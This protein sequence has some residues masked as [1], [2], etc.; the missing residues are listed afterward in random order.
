MKS[1]KLFYPLCILLLCG[2]FVNRSCTSQKSEKES[3]AIPAAPD[4]D[5]GAFPATVIAN[6]HVRM[7]VYLPDAEKGL[8]RGTRFDWSGVIGSVR[9]KDHE[10]FGYWKETHDPLFHED[11]TGP[12]EGFIEPG[13]G[14]AE[15]RP[16]EGFIRIGVGI[17]EKADEPAFN[18]RKTYKILDHGRWKT[19]NGT[20]WISFTHQ[21]NNNS[22]YAYTY[23]KTIKLKDDGFTIE[24]NLLNTGALAIETD[25]FNHNFFMIDGEPSGTSFQLSFPFAI[26]TEDDLK[27]YLEIDE[28]QLSFIGDLEKD[29]SVFL[30]LEGYSH[31]PQDH[32]V[33]VLNRKTGAGVTFTVDQPIYR[34]AFWA[35]RT[36]LSPE[37]SVWISVAPGREH[38]WISD[39]T[40]FIKAI[41]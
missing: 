36:T 3:V 9:F 5:F 1:L 16:G 6:D 15:A 22:G 24:H 41:P 37:N 40:L 7:K 35:C 8:Y 39:Y 2:V 12:V 17:I 13:L 25:Q 21:L 26:S 14:Y 34:M 32:R 29:S 20:D 18:W 30:L 27:H 4:L 19:E 33:T 10:Y 23:R 28:R 11:L 38:Q 31:D